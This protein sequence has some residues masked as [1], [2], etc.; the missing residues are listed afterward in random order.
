MAVV[1]PF[2]HLYGQ[3]HAFGSCG[4]V[5]PYVE[6]GRGSVCPGP[7]LWAAAHVPV[8]PSLSVFPAL[9]CRSRESAETVLGLCCSH[10]FLLGNRMY[11][12]SGCVSGY[13]M[14]QGCF[15]GR[16]VWPIFHSGAW[17]GVCMCTKHRLGVS[18]LLFG[19]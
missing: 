10:A 11:E 4:K 14:Q 19:C 15:G 8:S 9:P 5:G 1:I 16:R 3:P 2:K 6:R 7:S 18:A 17:L 12:L 13:C